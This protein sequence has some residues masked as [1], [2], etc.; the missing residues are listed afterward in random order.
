MNYF[1]NNLLELIKHNPDLT[2][3]VC[4]YNSDAN[5]DYDSTVYFDLSAY[6]EEL[7][8]YNDEVWLDYDD[9]E[10][11]IRDIFADDDKYINL[12][13][14]EFDKAVED[15]IKENYTFKKYI[16]IYAR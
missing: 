10:D 4:S 13:D 3:I 16:C 6:I 9:V 14:P 2:V 5:Y 1:N 11:R 7:T 12:S 15:Y 8:L